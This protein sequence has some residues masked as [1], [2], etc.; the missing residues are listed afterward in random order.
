MNEK[1]INQLLEAMHDPIDE[2]TLFQ[3][4]LDRLRVN[5]REYVEASTAT[6]KRAIA[7]VAAQLAESFKIM[8]ENL[9]EQTE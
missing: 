8:S 5:I 1:E 4:G 7:N 9:M 6:I 3:A 2:D